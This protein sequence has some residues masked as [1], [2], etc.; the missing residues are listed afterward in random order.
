MGIYTHIF[1]AWATL[2]GFDGESPTFADRELY[3]NG[4][5]IADWNRLY[6]IKP[7]DLRIYDGYTEGVAKT[8]A[9][10]MTPDNFYYGAFDWENE[11]GK[12]I[13]F[14]KG[15]IL[16]NTEYAYLTN[17][18]TG[19]YLEVDTEY[20]SG[21]VHIEGLGNNPTGDYIC[22]YL[23]FSGNDIY[24]DDYD[25]S[26]TTTI[27]VAGYL[28]SR[29]N[30]QVNEIYAYKIDYDPESSDSSREIW[31]CDQQANEWSLLNVLPQFNYDS[32]EIYGDDGAHLPE[33]VTW[34]ETLASYFVPS[35]K[36]PMELNL[37]TSQANEALLGVQIATH[38]SLWAM[39][40][41]C[42]VFIVALFKMF[43][44]IFQRR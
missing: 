23:D 7:E 33:G 11:Y 2:A 12:R 35:V 34:S 24:A 19:T 16:T 29:L 3:A 30:G 28:L 22:T 6:T 10:L 26:G 17:T 14:Y 5:L 38:A 13:G 21:F 15:A 20:I 18:E 36:T 9:E 37:I 43:A 27:Y 4:V 40:I 32:M 8:Y 25:S 31:L 1:R 39:G 44:R 41:G 42:G